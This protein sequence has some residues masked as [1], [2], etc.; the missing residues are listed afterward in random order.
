MLARVEKGLEDERG[1]TEQH[2]SHFHVRY[3]GDSHED[4]GREILRALEQH[5]ATLARALDYQ[6]ANPIPVILFSREAY[7]DAS[8]APAWSGGVFDGTDGRIRIPI[9][10]LTSSLT[11]YM[12]D[13]LLHEL[14]HAFVND[15]TKGVAT[16]EIQEG[17]AQY[18]EGKRSATDASPQ[19]LAAIADGRDRGVRA[20]YLAALSYVEYLIATRGMGGIN[21]LLRAMGETGSV[22]EAF[23]RVHGCSYHDSR[24]AWAQHLRQQYGS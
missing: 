20:F 10:G 23:Q 9:G 1:M 21:D 8:G 12:D 6:P 3:D 14:T 16:R 4:V 19:V 11:P 2:L 7:F 5:Y 22:D 17:L 15:R 18:M 24:Q 13:T